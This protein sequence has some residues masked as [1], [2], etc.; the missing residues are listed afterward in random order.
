MAKIL[1]VEDDT[2]LREI[3]SVRLGAEGYTM[4]TAT[5]GEDALAKVVPFGPDLIVSDVMMPKISGFEMLDLLK[6]N[7]ATKHIKTIL[8]T[9]LSSEQQRERGE[10]LGADRYLVKSQVGIEDLVRVVHEV[11]GDR[12]EVAAAPVQQAPAI[13]PLLPTPAVQPVAPPPRPAERSAASVPVPAPRPAAPTPPLMS[14]VP[15]NLKPQMPSGPAANQSAINSPAAT[16]PNASTSLPPT[17]ISVP[18]VGN[19]PPEHTPDL[20]PVPVPDEGQAYK[21]SVE[22]TQSTP[23]E[24]RTIQP[25][26]ATPGQSAALNLGILIKNETPG[27]VASD[28]MFPESGG[29]IE[30]D[31]SEPAKQ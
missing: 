7:E 26:E 5:D 8:M 23:H 6:A 11:L 3:Y 16:M 31:T 20:P 15:D 12:P 21:P 17:P 4:M 24:Q 28:T 19:E 25:V 18:S 30:P 27:T 14:V 29:A 9:A 2:A 10:G 1:L 22:L 13:A